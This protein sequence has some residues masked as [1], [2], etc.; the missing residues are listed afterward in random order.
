M[1][2]DFPIRFPI[3]ALS[4]STLQPLGQATPVAAAGGSLINTGTTNIYAARDANINTTNYVLLGP[5]GV[6]PWPANTPCYVWVLPGSGTGSITVLP[7]VMPY[8]PGTPLA[9]SG[10]ASAGAVALGYGSNGTD[11]SATVTGLTAQPL[12]VFTAHFTTTSG[13]TASVSVSPSV[14]V[15]AYTYEQYAVSGNYTL[16][17]EQ[18]YTDATTWTGGSATVTASWSGTA[19]SGYEPILAVFPLTTT[20]GTTQQ[21]GQGNFG[22]CATGGGVLLSPNENSLNVGDLVAMCFAGISYNAGPTAPS[23]NVGAVYPSNPWTVTLYQPGNLC[24]ALATLVNGVT[25]NQKFQTGWLL[26]NTTAQGVV[27]GTVFNA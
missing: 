21:D 12:I 2:I 25:T 13:N 4:G 7:F 18:F 16:A 11:V 17:I 26:D 5:G 1:P 22:T 10:Q 6:T 15:I 3:P 27:L 8:A 19:V 24:I 9:I 14:G 20:A 23:F